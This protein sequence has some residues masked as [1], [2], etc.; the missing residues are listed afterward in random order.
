MNDDLRFSRI[1][2]VDDDPGLQHVIERILGRKYEVV[3]TSE[4]DEALKLNVE[5]RPDLAILDI[6]MPLMN[7]FELMRQLQGQRADIDVIIMTGD[8]AEPDSNLVRAIDEGA[9][10]FVQ[11]PFE[12][13][14]LLTLVS[15]CLELRQLRRERQKHLSRLESELHDAQ[16]FQLSFLPPT[17]ANVGKLRIAAR[18]LACQELAGDFYDYVT[19]DDGSVAVLVADVVGHGA[20]AAMMTG[21]VKSSFRAAHACDYDP[22]EVIQQL[23]TSL[24]VFED[25]RFVT[26]FCARL[27]TQRGVLEFANA[28]H[29][30]AILKRRDGTSQMLEATGPLVC[31]ALAGLPFDKQA[32]EIEPGDS[33]FVYTDGVAEAE[34][35]H[36]IFGHGRIR[37]LIS[38]SVLEDPALL[39]WLL[40]R[41]SDFA[42]SNAYEDDVTIMT[43]GVD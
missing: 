12:R 40:E 29:P 36:E 34:S 41:L 21:V 37:S 3:C 18:Y 24:Q 39:D 14:V 43:V 42:G 31:S 38:Q 19:A 15:R 33:L 16:Q 27:D 22:I 26:V 13:R 11:K 25:S 1:L 6:Y 32:V 20:S 5:F 35:P 2:V 17:E 23:R 28:G 10:Y 8:T 4:P 9:F 7:G 30:P